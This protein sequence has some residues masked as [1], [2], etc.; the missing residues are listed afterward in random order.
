MKLK[1]LKTQILVNFCPIVF[2]PEFVYK[3]CSCFLCLHVYPCF[4]SFGNPILLVTFLFLFLGAAAFVNHTFFLAVDLIQMCIAVN[5]ARS[6]FNK[7]AINRSGSSGSKHLQRNYSCSSV[8]VMLR[9]KFKSFFQ[10][11]P[12]QPVP[13]LLGFIQVGTLRGELKD[14]KKGFAR[15]DLPAGSR[16]GPV[17]TVSLPGSLL[18][19]AHLENHF[20]MIAVISLLCISLP[21][22]WLSYV[23][24]CI[25]SQPQH[26]TYFKIC[27]IF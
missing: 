20:A 21:K 5:Y 25:C 4:L 14:R 8:E 26:P 17:R 11:F 24:A 18:H 13:L 12:L 2:P 7:Q 27:I 22:K 23:C 15:P 3:L 1:K 19:V 9:H 6:I 10:L 16:M